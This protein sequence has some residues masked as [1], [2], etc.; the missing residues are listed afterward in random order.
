MKKVIYGVLAFS[1]VLTLAVQNANFGNLDLILAFV[2]KAI[3]AVIPIMFGL[4]IIFFFWGLIEFIRAS[5]D[6]KARAEG[7]GRMIYGVIAIAVMVALYGLVAWL[8]S[9]FGIDTTITTGTLPTIPAP[10]L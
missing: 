4:A 10:G 8:G 7:R 2:Q 1:P 5:G 9:T 3:K 6:P